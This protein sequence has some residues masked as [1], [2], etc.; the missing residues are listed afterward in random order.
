MSDH[1]RLEQLEQRADRLEARQAE[2]EAK[3]E[4]IQ[5]RMAE[6]EA[7]HEQLMGLLGMRAFSNAMPGNLNELLASLAKSRLN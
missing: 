4:L 6:I 7:R 2:Q 3:M 1:E 5:V